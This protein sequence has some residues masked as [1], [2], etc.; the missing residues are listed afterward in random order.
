MAVPLQREPETFEQVMTSLGADIT[1][2]FNRGDAKACAAY[3]VEDATL[4]LPDRPVIKGREAIET[5]LREY[6]ALARI[7]RQDRAVIAP[8]GV[9]SARRRPKSVALR[10]G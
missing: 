9:R 6:T 1:E 8:G 7:S 5:L 2:A 4:F 3:Y 10:Y